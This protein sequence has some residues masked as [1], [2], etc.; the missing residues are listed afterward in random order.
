MPPILSKESS[1]DATQLFNLLDSICETENKNIDNFLLGSKILHIILSKKN[2][3]IKISNKMV[4][5]I[6]TTVEKY[7]E[8]LHRILLEKNV[9]FDQTDKYVNCIFGMICHICVDIIEFCHSL[10]KRRI[11]F[12][13][14]KPCKVNENQY[15]ITVIEKF[16]NHV[17]KMMKSI[18]GKIH[19]KYSHCIN[20]ITIMSSYFENFETSFYRIMKLRW[21]FHVTKYFFDF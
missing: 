17:H 21:I 13:K 3:N 16:M 4:E 15:Q 14:S 7:L 12:I 11:T 10:E 5:S 2:T 20:L 8:K 9:T 6:V 18:V 1:Y 19:V